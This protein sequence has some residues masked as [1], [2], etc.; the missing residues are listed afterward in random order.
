MDRMYPILADVGGLT[1]QPIA[2]GYVHMCIV[3][4][5]VFAVV[6]SLSTCYSQLIH[7]PGYGELRGHRGANGCRH[8]SSQVVR[9]PHIGRCSYTCSITWQGSTV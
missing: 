9:V 1:S 2:K 6:S 8:V 3:V 4:C 5:I 7:M